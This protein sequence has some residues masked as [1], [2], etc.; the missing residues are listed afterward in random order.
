MAQSI[1][2]V[3][4]KK[5]NGGVD[6]S[7]VDVQ[8]RDIQFAI[9]IEFYLLVGDEIGV[10]LKQSLIVGHTITIP[11]QTAEDNIGEL[12]LEH[13]SIVEPS[14]LDTY[15]TQKIQRIKNI[16]SYHI[17][18]TGGLTFF[19][20]LN[21]FSILAS[22][23]YFITDENREEKYLEI[24]NTGDADLIESLEEYLDSY[25]NI[26]PIASMQKSMKQVEIDINAATS[27]EEVDAASAIFDTA[28]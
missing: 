20:A 2:Y 13:F 4:V 22:K 16:F 24:I 11:V 25:D 26:S 18:T 12:T 3:E 9:P 27:E 10:T 23:G 8:F 21:S 7:V 1:F 5:I 6:Y 19:A 14:D 28:S 15:K 17:V